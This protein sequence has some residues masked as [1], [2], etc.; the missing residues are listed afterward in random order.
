MVPPSCPKPIGFPGVDADDDFPRRSLDPRSSA[1][2]TAT[3]NRLPPGCSHLDLGVFRVFLER[4][5]EVSNTTFEYFDDFSL[6]F[7]AAGG[8]PVPNSDQVA[9]L[10]VI[11][12]GCG[13]RKCPG[14]ASPST[15]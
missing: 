8:R 5:D 12:G 13:G 3:C 14:P 7:A 1:R 4:P 9:V 11:Q 6:R 10:G 2:W 15:T